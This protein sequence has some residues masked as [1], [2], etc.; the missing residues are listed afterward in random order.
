MHQAS[1]P[2]Q[3]GSFGAA[4]GSC[5]PGLKCSP[6]PRAARRGGRSGRGG[7]QDHVLRTLRANSR[8]RRGTGS[9]CQPCSPSSYAVARRARRYPIIARRRKAEA[10]LCYVAAKC[11]SADTCNPVSLRPALLLAA[12][13]LAPAHAPR[14]AAEASRPTARG[15]GG[16]PTPRRPSSRAGAGAE[17]G[18]GKE[19]L[20]IGCGGSIASWSRSPGA[21]RRPRA[22]VGVEDPYSNAHSENESLSAGGL[23]EV[24][25]QRRRPL[26][27][28]SRT[29]MKASRSSASRRGAVAQEPRTGSAA[30]AAGSWTYPRDAA[31]ELHHAEGLAEDP[32]GHGLERAVRPEPIVYPGLAVDVDEGPV[33]PACAE[34]S[35]SV[36]PRTRR[37]RCPG[38]FW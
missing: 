16:T 12:G 35:M 6:P 22:A 28:A 24:H 1:R 15:R 31:C 36:R 34:R 9:E 23:Q 25:A 18:F 3:Y 29:C 33:G 7:H 32:G 21:R 8:I 5:R 2:S 11:R 26:R 37:G 19:T 10:R 20:F 30:W 27:E 17:A 38:R 4:A 14:R 13:P